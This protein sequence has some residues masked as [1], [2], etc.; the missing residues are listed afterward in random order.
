MNKLIINKF[1][2]AFGIKRLNINNIDNGINN[3]LINNVI[4]AANGVF[5]TSFA[6]TFECLKKGEQVEERIEKVQFN[7]QIKIGASDIKS[8]DLSKKVLVFSR[9]IM[10]NCYI[11]SINTQLS[12]MAMIPEIQRKADIIFSKI[13]IKFNEIV[14]F[15]KSIGIEEKYIP[16]ALDIAGLNDE[17]QVITAFKNLLSH[18]GLFDNDNF[19]FLASLIHFLL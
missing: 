4:Y 13:N 3:C 15:L 17:L 6:N 11:N 9:E 14:S 12:K 5:K 1:E 8:L 2:N 7:Y 18:S 10:N 19:L 16:K